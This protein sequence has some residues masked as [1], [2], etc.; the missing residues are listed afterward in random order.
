MIIKINCPSK[1][2]GLRAKANNNNN[3]FYLFFLELRNKQYDQKKSPNVYKSCP[4]MISVKKLKILT[5]LQKC[6]RMWE[7]WAN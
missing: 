6:L 2:I 5:P 3:S 7:I 4:K 1:I